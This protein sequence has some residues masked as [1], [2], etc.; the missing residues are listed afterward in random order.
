MY[1]VRGVRYQV[2]GAEHK[3][4]MGDERTREKLRRSRARWEVDVAVNELPV[5]ML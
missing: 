3:T 4:K 5:A 2:S 1:W